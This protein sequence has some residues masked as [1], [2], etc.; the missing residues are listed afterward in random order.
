VPKKSIKHLYIKFT[1]KQDTRD[2]VRYKT[3]DK[4]SPSARVEMKVRGS[5]EAIANI[6]EDVSAA[7]I[8]PCFS[9]DA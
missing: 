3:R 5:S 6:T 1:I 7:L 8:N 4:K 9:Y 2:F